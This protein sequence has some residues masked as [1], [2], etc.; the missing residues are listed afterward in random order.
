M[1]R[2]IVLYLRN[3]PVPKGEIHYIEWRIENKDEKYS[4]YDRI[5]PLYSCKEH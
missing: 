1:S 2:G 4:L 5:Y 3:E